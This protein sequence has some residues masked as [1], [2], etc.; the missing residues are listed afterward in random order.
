[1][2]CELTALLVIFG[3]SFA[4]CLLLTPLARA[5]ADRFGPVDRPDGR[6]KIHGKP[7]PLAGGGAVLLALIGGLAVSPLGP[8]PAKG[9]FAEQGLFPPAL[10]LASL[11]IVILGLV[12]DF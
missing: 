3:S 11:G 4:L 7:T 9:G 5:W 1:M 10:L 12:C 2:G 6:R 8:G